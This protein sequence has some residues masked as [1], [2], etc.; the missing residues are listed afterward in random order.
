MILISGAI[1]SQ[2]EWTLSNSG[3]PIGY[4]PNDFAVASNGDVYVACSKWETSSFVPKLLKSTDNGA[5]WTEIIMTG[6]DNLQNTNS[7]V[8][9]GSKLL[10]S[11]SN[12]TNGTYFIYSSVDNG[13]NWTLSNSGVPTGY[14]PNDFAAASNGDVYVACSKWETSSFV[15]KLLKST[16]N[17]TNWTE[18]TMNGVDNLQNT[19]SIVFSGS[20]L[21]LS[22]SNST[23]GTYFIYSSVDNG[24][25]WTLSNSGVP[26]GY[27]PNDFT[28][29]SN[30]DVYVACSKWETSSFV[31]KLLKSTDNGTNWTEITMNG[32]DNL[33]N[34]N[35]IAE[36]GNKL[37]ISGSNS[38]TGSYYIYSS[39][40]PSAIINI[41]EQNNIM[42][43]P[44]PVRNI[45]AIESNSQIIDGITITDITGKEI[46]KYNGDFK[47]KEIDLSFLHPN[48][49]F[50]IIQQSN[51]FIISKII[52][53]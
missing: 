52:K 49:Y 42:I 14:S 41:N 15:P 11:G 13:L 50:V 19:N 37:V 46:I 30:G 39:S 25:N 36:T 47:N 53:Q 20:K 16:D 2:S 7:I 28:V 6:I 1:Y 8:F 23:S 12:S 45:L 43:S 21:L 33:Q 32:V 29:A 38:T 5:N 3:V 48:L 51:K 4:S 44:N 18:I 35:S 40:L 10:L 26:T 31:P 17:G 9:S 27:S 34:T 24:L 22:G